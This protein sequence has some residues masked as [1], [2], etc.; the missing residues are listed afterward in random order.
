MPKSLNSHS[1]FGI[2]YAHHFCFVYSFF[3]VCIPRVLGAQIGF[4]LTLGI[5]DAPS[6]T[7]TD[8]KSLEST[9]A[10]FVGHYSVFEQSWH[11]GRKAKIPGLRKLKEPK[12]SQHIYRC[13]MPVK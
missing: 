3:F 9:F 13:E 12:A 8:N 7:Q 11:Y 1:I 10:Q 2:L 6:I 4:N 5:S